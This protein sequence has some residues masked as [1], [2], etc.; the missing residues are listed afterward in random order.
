MAQPGDEVFPVGVPVRDWVAY[1][2]RQRPGKTAVLCIDS[3]ESRTWRELD[4]CVGAVAAG[5]RDEF[6]VRPGDRVC[7]LA[8]ND[9]RTFELHFACVRLG[10]IFP[11][12]NWRLEPAELLA[13]I[14]DRGPVM[15]VHGGEH[16]AVA[17][18]L[19]GK[20]A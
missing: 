15:L 19:A 17:R 2:G 8:E 14:D 1:H 13:L 5:L 18:R 4:Q 20:R 7:L 6:G 3:G 9:V 16:A 11:P 10:G 12:L